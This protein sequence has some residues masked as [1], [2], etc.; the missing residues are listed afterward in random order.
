MILLMT[1]ASEMEADGDSEQKSR[2]DFLTTVAKGAVAMGISGAV[3]E[4][5][6]LLS[7]FGPTKGFMSDWKGALPQLDADGYLVFQND[8]IS[9]DVVVDLIE[10]TGSFIFLF[11]GEYHGRRDMIPGI[12]SR[13]AEG[14]LHASSRRC[15]HE[16]CLVEFKDDKVVGSR[17]FKKIWFCHCHDGVFDVVDN[18]KVLAGPAPT[19]L[20]KFEIQLEDGGNRIRL[21]CVDSLKRCGD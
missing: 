4:A 3:L 15:T 9:Q 14:N 1:T 17:S 16:G 5:A 10:K 19:P 2:R 21:N 6:Y 13:D 12:I 7:F 8:F 20:P 11:D 18:G